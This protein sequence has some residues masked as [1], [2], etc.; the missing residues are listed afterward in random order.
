MKTIRALLILLIILLFLS[1][2][3]TEDV[4]PVEIPNVEYSGGGDDDDEPIIQGDTTQTN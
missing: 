4:R 2:C 3:N 1:S